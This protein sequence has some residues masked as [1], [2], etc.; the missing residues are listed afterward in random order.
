ML[1]SFFYYAFYASAVLIYGVGFERSIS[2][3]QEKRG[4]KLKAVKMFI[5]VSSSSALSHL[6]VSGFLVPADLAE[7]YPFATFLIFVSISLFVESIIRITAKTNA[8]EFS[9]ALLSVFIGLTESSSIAE[10]VFASCVSSLSFFIMI[11]LLRAIS[12]RLSDNSFAKENNINYQLFATAAV[13]VLVTLCWNV[14][15]LSGGAV[16]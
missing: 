4:A 3:S 2:L 14:S 13:L 6:F 1:S 10:C 16:K 9:V 11:P 5:C 12:L 7:L 8:S 15:W